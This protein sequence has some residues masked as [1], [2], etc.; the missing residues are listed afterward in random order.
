LKKEKS[1]KRGK[2]REGTDNY[3]GRDEN[4]VEKE[5]FF[6]EKGSW[7]LGGRRSKNKKGKKNRAYAERYK[8]GA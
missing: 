7:G 1:T 3:L 2:K 8:A 5:K 6:E 4:S